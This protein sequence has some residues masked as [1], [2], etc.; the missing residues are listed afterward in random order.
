MTIDGS[1]HE[2]QADA[3]LYGRLGPLAG[4]VFVASVIVSSILFGGVG[5]EPSA[6][7][8]EVVAQYNDP[9][10]EVVAAAFVAM[11]GIGPLLVFLS[12]E[13]HRMR[14]RG[15][16]WEADTLVLGFAFL[17]LAAM[18]DTGV[19]L[20]GSVAADHGHE[21]VAQAANDFTWNISLLY[22]PGLLAVGLAAASAG[23]RRR[24]LPRWLGG[25]G[26][27]VCL[28]AVMPWIGLFVGLG[29][30]LA[31][32]ITELVVRPPESGQR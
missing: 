27:V 5:A 25:F 7:A 14:I 8:G 10:Q 4:L 12:I 29:W 32:S 19:D 26:V 20:M 1:L 15:A 21:V 2:T 6:T 28:G 24:G 30:M 23:L 13:R 3:D 17:A 18:V 22:S 11:L 9:E 16:T 31:L